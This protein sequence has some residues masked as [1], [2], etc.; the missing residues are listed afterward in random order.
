[1]ETPG[2]LSTFSKLLAKPNEIREDAVMFVGV[3][4]PRVSSAGNSST[5]CF[6]C[7]IEQDFNSDFNSDFNVM[8][9]VDKT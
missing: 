6:N 3:V 8:V 4:Q 1:M 7:P 9:A 2:Y 5:R